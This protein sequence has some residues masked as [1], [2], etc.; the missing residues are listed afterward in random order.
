[1]PRDLRIESRMIASPEHILRQ[2]PDR[3]RAEAFALG[4]DAAAIDFPPR[5][6]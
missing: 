6:L 1:M 2:T 3:R 5:A 4:L